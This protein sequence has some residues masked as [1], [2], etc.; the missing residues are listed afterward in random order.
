MD[1]ILLAAALDPV[2]TMQ[3]IIKVR[4]KAILLITMALFLL[5][6]FGY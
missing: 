1:R 3:T 2:R 5:E 6:Y 4:G